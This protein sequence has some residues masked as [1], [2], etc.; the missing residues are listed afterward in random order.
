MEKPASGLKIVAGIGRFAN[1][2]RQPLA[3]GAETSRGTGGFRNRSRTID[4]VA[5]VLFDTEKTEPIQKAV[6]A[7]DP[8]RIG[9]PKAPEAV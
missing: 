5:C 6:G 2:K 4:A 8:T 3:A 7:S 9:S 1:K